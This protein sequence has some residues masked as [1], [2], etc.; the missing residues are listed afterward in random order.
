MNP[1][2]QVLDDLLQLGRSGKQ[3]VPSSLE[4]KDVA[5][6]N[7]VCANEPWRQIAKERTSEEVADLIRGLILYSRA[8]GR[9]IGG[10]VSPVIGLYRI[11][12]DRAPSWEPN[13]TRWIVAYRT[14]PYEPFGTINDEGATTHAEYVERRQLRVVRAR[15]NE[16]DEVERQE[17]ARKIRADRATQRVAGAVRRGDLL[18][19]KALLEEGAD[20]KNA[21][22]NGE[23]LL[24]LAEQNGRGSVAEFLRSLGIV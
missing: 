3:R 14:N 22:P 18:A 11:L 1:E 5:W 15:A 8:S 24:E 2:P 20:L 7:L 9:Q 10:S 12:V 6:R 17:A 13:L 23:S 4:D 16:T 21:L 19:V